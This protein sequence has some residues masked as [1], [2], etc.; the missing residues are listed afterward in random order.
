MKQTRLSINQNRR[1]QQQQHIAESNASFIAA[2]DRA[3]KAKYGTDFNHSTKHIAVPIRNHAAEHI[4]VG[5]VISNVLSGVLHVT[6]TMFSVI[7][8]IASFLFLMA[9]IRD[10][11]D[12][13]RQDY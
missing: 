12:N 1:R 4:S 6:G 9:W 3:N 10:Y 13:H 5:N 7:M 8:K 11:S 2:R